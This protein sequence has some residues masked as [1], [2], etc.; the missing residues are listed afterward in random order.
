M[1]RIKTP[2]RQID[3]WGQGKD[4]FTD[5]NPQT[6]LSSTQL[7]SAWFDIL[8]EEVSNAVELAGFALSPPLD[9]GPNHGLGDLTQLFQ[10][11]QAIAFGANPDLSAYVLKSGDTMSG[12]LIINHSTGVGLQVNAPPGIDSQMF[13]GVGGQVWSVGV[14]G[15]NP[16]TAGEFWIYDITA[17][18]PRLRIDAGGRVLLGDAIAGGGNR[19]LIFGGN[20]PGITLF[21][22]TGNA[23]EGPFGIWNSAALLSFG[24]VNSATGDPLAPLVSIDGAGN[25]RVGAATS[26]GISY[27]FSAAPHNIGFGWDSV[28]LQ[29]WVDGAFIGNLAT[30]GMLGFLPLTGG[31]L[32]NPG[33]LAVNGT[34]AVIGNFSAANGGDLQ[35]N[36]QV[37]A[38]NVI[39]NGVYGNALVQGAQVTST[40][41]V[42]GVDIGATGSISAGTSVT[43]GGNVH[44]IGSLTAIG[45]VNV[46]G[47]VFGL[48]GVLSAGPTMGQNTLILHPNS[49]QC[50]YV[51]H[52]SPSNYWTAG[53][54][55][56]GRY[57]ISLINTTM[58]E[59][60]QSGNFYV[61]QAEHAYKTGNP[62]W[63][64]ISDARLKTDVAP[65]QRGLAAIRQLEPITYGYNGAAGFSVSERRFH[66]MVAQDILSIM[67][68]MVGQLPMRLDPDDEEE[69]LVYTMN[70]HPL[71]MALVNAVKELADRLERLEGGNPSGGPGAGAPRRRRGLRDQ[72]EDAAQCRAIAARRC[73]ARPARRRR[74]SASPPGAPAMSAIIRGRR[75]S[76]AATTRIGASCAPRSS[77]RSPIVAIAPAAASSAAPRWSIISSRSAPHRSSASSALICKRS[78]FPAISARPTKT[79]TASAWGGDQKIFELTPRPD[80][81]VGF[82]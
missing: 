18:L 29:A 20:S 80:C 38:T 51:Q 28:N 39:A 8:Q 15:F 30:T 45:D 61:P 2:T 3:K 41:N 81:A 12:P 67:P 36:N 21:N 55:Q 69:T 23:A 59:L 64:G 9:G 40:G 17:A 24:L 13:F 11:M 7:E 57:N 34:L 58:L 5:G 50:A 78:V 79:N 6:G 37:I 22:T 19:L 65:Y 49:A 72:G 33:N 75:R 10:A 47:G 1:F 32:D 16:P 53:A 54:N 71:T 63:E 31:T 44:A 25:L 70:Y 4:G 27:R 68:E 48:Y 56:P 26:N 52:T 14:Q 73:F 66:G 77:P 62:V 42:N 35:C 43:A 82:L 76:R 74:P 60:D 46:A